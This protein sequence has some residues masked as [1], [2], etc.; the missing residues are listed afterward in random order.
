[1]RIQ[2]FI[3]LSEIY[4]ADLRRW[5]EAERA[6]AEDAARNSVEAASALTRAAELDAFLDMSNVPAPTATLR[7]RIGNSAP[8]RR[9]ISLVGLLWRG[10]GLAG[11][12]IAGAAAGMLLAGLL[13]SARPLDEETYAMTAFGTPF[14]QGEVQ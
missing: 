4:G 12:G 11:M 13:V 9:P 8:A 1:M 14:D 5:P 3:E 2:R 6:A 10:V 7:E